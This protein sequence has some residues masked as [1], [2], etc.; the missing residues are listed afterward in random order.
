MLIAGAAVPHRLVRVDERNG[1][2]RDAEIVL[3]VMPGRGSAQRIEVSE[4]P[5]AGPSPPAI[6]PGAAA[7]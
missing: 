3:V 6:T 4:K 1:L 5:A 2:E 7:A